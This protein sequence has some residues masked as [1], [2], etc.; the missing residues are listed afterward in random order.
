MNKDIQVT[1]NIY[2]PKVKEPIIK[3]FYIDGRANSHSTGRLIGYYDGCKSLGLDVVVDNIVQN[4]R[5][6]DD[7][8]MEWLCARMPIAEETPADISIPTASRSKVKI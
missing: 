2:K 7:L 4:Y 1:L 8:L 3:E 6:V 5:P